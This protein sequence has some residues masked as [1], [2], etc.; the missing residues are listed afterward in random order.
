MGYVRRDQE[1]E[2]EDPLADK[3]TVYVPSSGEP[4]YKDRRPKHGDEIEEWVDLDAHSDQEKETAVQDWWDA[5]RNASNGV[6]TW[7][8]EASA[9]DWMA[10]AL[11]DDFDAVWDRIQ[12]RLDET[13]NQ[14]ELEDLPYDWWMT[15]TGGNATET[16]NENG[17]TGADLRNFNGLPAAIQGAA[18][19]G[20]ASGV[21]GIK[22]TLDGQT[23]GR[24]VAPYV[25]EII[26]SQIVAARNQ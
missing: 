10:E 18:A 7:E 23:V 6:D 13:E 9:F 17:I 26:G 4:I 1:E 15:T 8:E 11:G 3:P 2:T 25:S 24:L 21:S 20:V 5:W 16:K 12:Q 14:N 19:S 22:V